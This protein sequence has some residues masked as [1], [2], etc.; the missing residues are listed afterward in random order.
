MREL[1][2]FLNFD[3]ITFTNV[4]AHIENL[5]K[6]LKALKI[7]ISDKTIIVIENH[8]LGS[9]L[10][11]FQFDTFYHEHP[12]T[13][14]F[15]SFRYISKKLGVNIINFSMPKRYGGNV[16]VYL[17]KK[18]NKNIQLSKFFK[19]ENNFINQF[20]IMEKIIIQWK[21]KKF[22]EI[23]KL[24]LKYGKLRAK[25][26]PAR[27]TILIELLGL[28]NNFIKCIYEKDG[29]PKIGNY[30]PGTNIEIVADSTIDMKD[31]SPLINFAWH[32]N[33][34]ITQYLKS[35]NF[36]GKIIPIISKKDM[37]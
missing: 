34:E 26:L 11:N 18:E 10:K 22:K 35:L 16:R 19:T 1:L 3:I 12:R 9:V 7:L 29:S 4:F 32:I 17:S 13:Y 20:K 28:N 14:S 25:A 23:N 27:A 2:H 5:N 31:K 30:V 21:Q 36:K 37:N 15:S 24:F 33:K 6:L 8:Y